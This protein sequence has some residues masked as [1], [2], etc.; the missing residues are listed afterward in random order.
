MWSSLNTIPIISGTP[1]ALL[2]LHGGNRQA[3]QQTGQWILKDCDNKALPASWF[4]GDNV[5]SLPIPASSK[6]QYIQT[7]ML[8]VVN[9]STTQGLIPVFDLPSSRNEQMNADGG[10]GGAVD[11][12]PIIIK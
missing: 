6:V 5:G 3:P 11:P 12:S 7:P 10:S 1:I 4:I 9:H 8:T 2:P